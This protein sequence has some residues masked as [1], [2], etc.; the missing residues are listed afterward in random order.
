MRP[1]PDPLLQRHAVALRPP[2]QP[3]QQALRLNQALWREEQGYP[4]GATESGRP[5]GSML[6]PEWAERGLNLMSDAAR[7]VAHR[8][9][10]AGAGGENV[11]DGARLFG[12]LLSSQPL[13]FSLFADLAEDHGLASRVIGSLLGHEFLNP[14]LA[15]PRSRELPGGVRSLVRCRCACSEHAREAPP[16]LPRGRCPGSRAPDGRLVRCR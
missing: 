4:V 14:C 2:E 1:L 16:E 7:A 6:D 5:M 8:E 15:H 11:V 13:C 3:W 12:N 10:N 9:A